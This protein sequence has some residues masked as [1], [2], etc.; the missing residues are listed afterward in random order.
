MHTKNP[1]MDERHLIDVITDNET[2]LLSGTFFRLR[3]EE[4]FKKS[5]E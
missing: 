1:E 2:G 5:Y 4:E 3:M